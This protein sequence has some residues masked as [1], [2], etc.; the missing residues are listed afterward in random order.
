MSDF[1]SQSIIGDPL[2]TSSAI[3]C[4]LV[5]IVLGI[6]IAAIYMVKNKYNKGL[7]VTIALLPTIVQVVIMLVNGN[8]GTGV[9]VMGAFGLVRFRS[10]PGSARDICSIFFAMA[11]GLATGMGYIFYAFLFFVLIGIVTV[12]LTVLPFGKSDDDVRY[13]RIVI[14]ESLDYEGLFDDLFD[15]YTSDSVLDKVKTTNM[16]TMF[17]LSY[18]VKLKDQSIPKAFIDEIRCRNGNLNIIISRPLANKEEL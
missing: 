18:T 5:S 14:P 15:Q 2:T 13:L 10:V 1:I 17:E 12:L 16:G 7:V 6:G 4:T 11:I 9:A 3:I 8:V